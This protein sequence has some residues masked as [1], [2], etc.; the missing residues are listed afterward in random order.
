MPRVRSTK[1]LDTAALDELMATLTATEQKA[2]A[3]ARW[4]IELRGGL[5]HKHSR[6]YWRF[7]TKAEL[8]GQVEA[9]EKFVQGIKDAF[10]K[11]GEVSISF[12]PG[13]MKW[14]DKLLAKLIADAKQGDADSDQVLRE[15][16]AGCLETR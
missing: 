16:A 14:D 6:D 7:S 5:S 2:V 10:A 4:L 12:L 1:K 9:G 13:P 8:S 11:D 15:T 3:S